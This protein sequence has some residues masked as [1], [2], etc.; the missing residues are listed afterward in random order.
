M[1]SV[2]CHNKFKRIV[3][4]LLICVLAFAGSYMTSVSSVAADKSSI[5]DLQN[6]LTDLQK[7]QAEIKK[8]IAKLQSD[9]S[10]SEALKVK[11]EEQIKLTHSEIDN[12]NTQLTLINEEIAQ[13][14]IDLKNSEQNLVAKKEKFKERLKAM[15]MTG[16]TSMLGILVSASDF[17]DFLYKSEFLKSVGKQDKQLLDGLNAEVKAINNQKKSLENKRNNITS[18]SKKL[19]TKQAELTTQIKELNGLISSLNDQK[20]ELQ[21]QY[22]ENTDDLKKLE[23]EIAEA[24]KNTGNLVY[25]GSDFLWPVPGYY[26]VSSHW[27]TAKRPNHT[28]IDIAS[29]GI[30]GK[31][32]IASAD[33]IV[34]L[35]QYYYGYGN[36]VMINHGKSST[37]GKVYVT[38]YGHASE[39]CVKKGQY[40]TAGTVIAK[41]G[42]TGNSSGPHLHFEIRVNSKDTNPM[43]YFS[44]NK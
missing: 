38:L 11:Y 28:G 16:D 44:S 35:S 3:S 20:T 42:N 43:S 30:Y 14:E 7:Q 19:T 39:L 6:E 18:L 24:S 33:G 36:C 4:I 31:N 9:I 15:A 13:I 41:V 29:S 8:Q 21:T 22:N 10:N 5:N 12:Y 2:H 17:S 32:I 37:N 34:T 1:N 25:S 40:V 23:K 27:R 26:K